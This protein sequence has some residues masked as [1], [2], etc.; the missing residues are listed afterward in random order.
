M[1]SREL[2]DSK[3]AAIQRSLYFVCHSATN[4]GTVAVILNVVA[5]HAADNLNQRLFSVE[6]VVVYG[7]SPIPAAAITT[8]QFGFWWTHRRRR[9][10]LL[11]LLLLGQH[12]PVFL[13]ALK[14]NRR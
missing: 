10:G 4:E 2:A 8:C 1:I 5:P 14:G 13:A 9:Q 7:G 12:L 3:M 11:Q 6:V